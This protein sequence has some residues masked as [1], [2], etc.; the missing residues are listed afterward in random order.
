MTYAILT[1]AIVFLLLATGLLL[2]FYR[3]PTRRRIADV[4]STATGENPRGAGKSVSL[5][6][7]FKIKLAA[8]SIGKLAGSFGD[9]YSGLE[10]RTSVQDRRMVLAGYRG[11]SAV[12]L[13]SGAKI[14]VP[15]VLCVIAFLSG[16]Y[17]W[18]AFIVFGVAL[19]LGYLL[20]DFWI[21]RCIKGRE[22]AIREGL[23][24]LLDL[25]VICLEA[26]LSTDQAALRSCEELKPGHPVIAD[27]V[28]LVMLEIRA[29]K[30]RVEAWKHLVDRTNVEGI[31]LLVSILVQAD[32]F[33]TGISKTLRI[34]AEAMRTQARQRV[35][36]MAAKT[37]VK[38][39]F[40]LV[41]FVFPAM[42]VVLLGPAVLSI[43][44]AF[45]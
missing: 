7:R 12:K 28:G 39:V 25:L 3:D 2:A 19:G 36:E 15:L 16:L 18:N 35:E 4:L 11:E 27:E 31:R 17:L 29:G 6:E 45:K 41:L 38:L 40:P 22:L 21:D 14:V 30:P 23:P 42:F 1:F 37:T 43:M 5:E 10:K 33:G 9:A 13:Y 24:D 32:Q 26:G 44:E 34:H 8:G 20:P